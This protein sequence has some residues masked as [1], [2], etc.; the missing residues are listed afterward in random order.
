MC[1]GID[2]SRYLVLITA[3][4][5]VGFSASRSVVSESLESPSNIE[6][7]ASQLELTKTIE[8]S[9]SGGQSHS[10][11][12]EGK[13]NQFLQLVVDQ[14]GI[15][16][17]IS[18]YEPD[19]TKVSEVDQTELFGPETIVGVMGPPG[20]YRLEVR[21]VVANA[22]AGKYQIVIKELRAARDDDKAQISARAAAFDAAAEG[23]ELV[24]KGDA[25]SLNAAIGKYQTALNL[26]RQANDKYWQAFTLTYNLGVTY[27]LLY[28]KQLALDAHNQAL[29]IFRSLKERSDEAG[30]LQNIGNVYNSLW[31]SVSEKRK[32]LDYYNQSLSILKEIGDHNNEGA[33]L[34][35][36][37]LL[38]Q[39]LGEYQKALD[40]YNQAL[41][42]QKALGDSNGEAIT[43]LNIG[44]AYSGLGEVRKALDYFNRSLPLLKVV[45][46]RGGEASA[47]RSIGSAY[48][49][50]G[51][52][53]Q[54]I[55]FHKQA[56]PIFQAVGDRSGEAD[57]LSGL[58]SAYNSLSEMQQ[59]LDYYNQ[60]LQLRKQIG[61][62][63]EE[64]V[65]LLSI[66]HVAGA[67]GGRHAALDYY[68]Q[69]LAIFTAIAD[70]ENGE[71]TALVGTIYS[72]LDQQQKAL[73]FYNRALPILRV[74][75]G[76]IK[77]AQ[78]L[79]KIGSAYSNLGEWEKAL[80]YFNL[81]LPIFRAA[82]DPNWEAQIL[83]NIGL[84][85]DSLG[86]LQKALDTYQQALG[87]F[88]GIHDRKGEAV[89][90]NNLGSVYSSLLEKKKA[91]DYY[92]EAW[93]LHQ[94]TGDRLREATMLNNIGLMY[95]EFDHHKEAME[96]LNTAL[97][98]ERTLGDTSGEATTLDNLGSLYNSLN[99]PQ[100]ALD[101]YYR[102]LAIRRTL[103]DRNGE[104]VT[105]SNLSGLWW[106]RNASLAILY[107]KQSVNVYQQL[108]G[109][110]AGLDKDVQKTFLRSVD[111]NH[112][113]LSDLLIAQDRLPE[114]HQVLN[115]FK[116][117]QFFDFNRDT[118]RKPSLL[119]LTA[120]ET[121]ITERYERITE[122]LQFT[123]Q[124]LSEVKLKISG[125]QPSAEETARL[126]QFETQLKSAS[127]EFVNFGKQMEAEFKQ[128]SSAKDR[129]GEIADTRELQ[130]ALRDLK[131]QT[132]QNAVAIYTLAGPENFR[133]LIITSDQIVAVSRPAKRDDVN[134]KALQLWG[135]LQSDQ[136]DPRPLSEE[137]YAVVFNP[138]ET[139]LPK[140][141]NTILW[142]LD[143]NLRYV[144]MG[145]LYDGKQ[146][147]VE[148]YNHAV[149]TR[150]DRERLT[151]AVSRQWT[152]LGLGSSEAHTVEVLGDKISFNA[153]PGVTEE[154]RQLFRQKGSRNGVLDGEV[155]PDAKFTKAAM[156]AALKQKRPLVHISSHFSF[157]P[158]DEARSFLL[159]GDGGVMTLEEMKNQL[160]LFSG[161][162]LLTLSACNTAAQRAGANGREIDGFA[163]LAQRLGA[164]SV[165]ATLWPVADNSTPWFMHEFYQS[166]QSGEG[167][168][169]AEA[170]RRAQ[171]ALLN[172]TAATQPLPAG[173][174]GSASPVQIVIGDNGGKRDGGGTRA[175][176]IFV[177]AQDAPLF[178]RDEKR[179]FAHPYYWAPFILIGNWK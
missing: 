4:V 20:Q 19:G 33:A 125:Q 173:E 87:L 177:E 68:N 85:Y 44:S 178:K 161:V 114:A 8:R 175:D 38:C 29:G 76:P 34:S 83:N 32:A 157:R 17:V 74:T 118:Q 56:L 78:T 121:L 133:S 94:A 106:R 120:H 140:G 162:E 159:L 6:Q 57:A 127:D 41:S 168:S 136:Y 158:G 123:G 2:L 176:M 105:L 25:A 18:L 9:I 47:L 160:D 35:N 63:R 3:A 147:L 70:P 174:K 12:I 117:Q 148:R 67:L 14:Q 154:L 179:P 24:D 152:G 26:F 166:R 172:G 113:L 90:L 69:A 112:R 137:L 99:E 13:T 167:L 116:D 155:L 81:A 138:I 149:F 156:L 134:T 52:T 163:E 98:I 115:L 119:T 54:A 1:P 91:L 88:K 132:R 28:K 171:L 60:A 36:T 169:K 96:F 45:G 43:L 75:G 15:D 92:L 11:T 150:A 102:S 71:T 7:Q 16:V 146:Y 77:E 23:G 153:L 22:S 126:Q 95:S 109:S 97:A 107:S 89:T 49:T 62:R 164:A 55:E 111:D 86:E 58:G 40:Y 65:L 103:G 27:R 66:G 108:R 53:Q 139:L 5:V 135:L 10:F 30:A 80:T 48:D 130:T 51:E 61:D 124:Q 110:I 46:N 79:E 170:V 145:T 50:L 131:Q 72:S 101:Y 100:K 144:P 141:T 64:A 37:G 59:A 84:V 82:G 39:S 143:G 151:R 122:R 104:A 129:V 73:E 31:E 21:P 42:V 93:R 142:S 165:M 128:A